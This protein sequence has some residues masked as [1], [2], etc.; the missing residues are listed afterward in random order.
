MSD[1]KINLV[2]SADAAARVGVLFVAV[3][4]FA[5]M[6]ESD[7][8]PANRDDNWLARRAGTSQTVS[9]SDDVSAS[10]SD[11]STGLGHSTSAFQTVSA[12]TTS[13]QPFP[14]PAGI[15]PGDYRVVDSLG[16][17]TTLNVTAEMVSSHRGQNTRDQ[18]VIEDADRSI[19]FIRIRNLTAGTIA[20][21]V[22][23]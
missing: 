6:W 10:T 20:E 13:A 15:V 23:R 18:Y 17:V 21:S 9:R 14:I 8:P 16:M 19:Y 7:T 4:I 11:E 1:S 2:D 12:H 22:R 5:A 3:A